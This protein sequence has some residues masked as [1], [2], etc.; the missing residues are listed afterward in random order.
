MCALSYPTSHSCTPQL[1]PQLT[2]LTTLR[3]RC[4]CLLA[5]AVLYIVALKRASTD[6]EGDAKYRQWAN[7][8]IFSHN[9][10]THLGNLMRPLY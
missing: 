8:E 1:T 2:Q 6:D 3:H 4:H 9:V 5:E 10:A 7:S